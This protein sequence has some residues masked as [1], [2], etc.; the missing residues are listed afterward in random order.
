MLRIPQTCVSLSFKRLA[1]NFLS[2]IMASHPS[3]QEFSDS[4]GRHPI[5]W[6]PSKALEH[7]MVD[8]VGAII[9][10]A[11]FIVKCQC[12]LPMICKMRRLARVLGRRG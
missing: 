8:S 4:K 3:G 2:P 7:S 12:P 11:A 9:G 1:N 5:L 10:R 6:A